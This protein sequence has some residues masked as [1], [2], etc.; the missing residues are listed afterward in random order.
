MNLY[1]RGFRKPRLKHDA[2]AQ[3]GTGRESGFT[4]IELMIAVVVVAILAAI[5][6]P[7]YNEQT[8]KSRR[9]EAKVA[10]MEIVQSKE[11]FLTIN[12]TYA[13]SPCPD[14]NAFYDITCPVG[15]ATAFSIQ[16]APTAGSAQA[17]DKCGSF[18]I[19]QTGARTISG[20]A[21]GVTAADCW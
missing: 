2:S 9:A 18:V 4:L 6:I 8:R 20:A 11:R 3:L 16:A 7:A 19:T 5:A 10:L 12:S 13:N 17:G 15:T 21:A 1:G 14:N